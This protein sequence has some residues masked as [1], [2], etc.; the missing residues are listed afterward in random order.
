[1]NRKFKWGQECN[2]IKISFKLNRGKKVSYKIVNK[3]LK[4]LYNDEVILDGELTDW[5]KTDTDIIF[6]ND[7]TVDFYVDKLYS[8]WWPYLLKGDEEYFEPEEYVHRDGAMISQGAR[9]WINKIKN[10][11]QD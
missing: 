10:E 2:S 8:K 6:I 9:E 4:I 3:K 1:M 11:E 7:D 5:I